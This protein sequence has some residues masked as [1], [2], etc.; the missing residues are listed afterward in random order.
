MVILAIQRDLRHRAWIE[1]RE[2]HSSI[3]YANISEIARRIEDHVRRE[4]PTPAVFGSDKDGDVELKREI[5]FCAATVERT[6]WRHV[7]ASL[8]K[9]YGPDDDEWWT[10]GIKLP[11]RKKC[12]ERM[13]E[14]QF[15]EDPYNY[16]DLVDFKEI[17]RDQWK[18]FDTACD[19]IADVYQ[20]KKELLG[21]LTR[22]MNSGTWFMEADRR[23]H[24]WRT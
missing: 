2:P 24:Q 4:Q 12:N 20:S 10:Q 8:Q 7:K 14:C 1:K 6:F 21:D 16:T 9:A 13:E 22:S 23:V 18:H 19:T 15:R 5:A 17:I 3:A 11:I